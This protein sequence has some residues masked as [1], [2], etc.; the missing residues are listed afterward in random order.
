MAT[1]LQCGVTLEVIPGHRPRCYCS[2]RCK[3]TAYRLRHG[4]NVRL[5]KRDTEMTKILRRFADVKARWLN[6]DFETYYLLQEV[7]AK[8]GYQLAI[9]IAE[10]II[11]EVNRTK[12]S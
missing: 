5:T 1:C 4:K 12:Q 10:C 2:D 8:Y 11:Q 3:Q 6:F 9:R 7:Q